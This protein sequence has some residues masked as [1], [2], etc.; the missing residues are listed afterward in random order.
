M[1][2]TCDLSSQSWAY[3]YYYYR[4]SDMNIIVPIDFGC[5]ILNVSKG[6]DL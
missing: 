1:Y 2:I 3:T 5:C 6:N 4:H